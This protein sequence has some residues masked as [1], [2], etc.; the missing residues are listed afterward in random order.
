[1]AKKIAV[2]VRDR[3]D[4]ALRMSLGITLLED[5]IDV[6][7]LDRPVVES[8]QNMTN[9]GTM[10]EMGIGLYTNFVGNGSLEYVSTRDIA[11]RLA[12]YDHILP[13]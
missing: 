5:T 6:Y 8:E 11:R 4:E 2:L 1:M 10:K 9:I 12:G 7:V 13:Y 3:Q